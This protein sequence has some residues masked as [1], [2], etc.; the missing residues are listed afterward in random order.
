MTLFDDVFRFVIIAEWLELNLMEF[1]FT[2][3]ML[4]FHSWSASFSILWTALLLKLLHTS[5][6]WLIFYSF[7]TSVHMLSTVSVC[8]P[9]HSICIFFLWAVSHLWPVFCLCLP[10]SFCSF[11]SE[12]FYLMQAI[13]YCYLGCFSFNSLCPS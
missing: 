7:H 12:F 5:L 8:G 9:D 11:A 3:S 4:V 13:N 6:K 10:L 2:I 1:I